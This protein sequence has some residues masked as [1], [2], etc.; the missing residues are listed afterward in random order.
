MPSPFHVIGHRG[1]RGLFPENT[2]G[3]FR[4]ARAL[5]VSHFEIDVGVLKDGTVVVHH[6][7]ALNPDTLSMDGRYLSGSLP[8]L[9]ALTW[10]D[11][12]DFSVGHLRPGSDTATRFPGQQPMDGEPIPKLLDVLE[13]DPD[14]HWTIELK[15]VPDRPDWTVSA[16]EMVERVLAVADA[17]GAASRITIQSF[18][19]RAPRIS[20]RL[21]PDIP[22]AWL[23][24]A[25][26]VAD[27]VLW[28]D[29]EGGMAAPDAIA[30]E[31]GGTWT[32]AHEDLTPEML[33]HAHR[34]G[35]VVIP[36][37]VND[38]ADMRRLMQWGVDGLITDYPDRLLALL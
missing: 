4:A 26:T 8:L 32:V 15:L 10:D 17:A 29:R 11:L 12:E 24:R 30:S 37:T 31:G 22:V 25:E 3:G 7:P 33:I 34:L 16:Q 27:P 36:W 1:A 35:L 2:I 23:T 9:N 21:R 18:D 14:L 6:D 20:R 5:G 38:P 19:W 28:W 13:I